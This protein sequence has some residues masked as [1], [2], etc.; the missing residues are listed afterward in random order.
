MVKPI[1]NIFEEKSF[2]IRLGQIKQII[3]RQ[4]RLK[5]EMLLTGKILI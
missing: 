3:N 1:S 2:N 4:D 5:Q